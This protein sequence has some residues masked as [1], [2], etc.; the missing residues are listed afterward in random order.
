MTKLLDQAAKL[1]PEHVAEVERAPQEAGESLFATEEKM[2][3]V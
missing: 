1:T 3:D 2:C